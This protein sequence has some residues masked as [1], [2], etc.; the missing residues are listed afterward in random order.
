MKAT[1]DT[2]TAQNHILAKWPGT[3][4]WGAKIKTNFRNA[5]E[6]CKNRKI[7]KNSK[8][9]RKF[10][11]ISENFENFRKSVKT[12]S[13]TGPGQVRDRSGT[14]PGQVQGQVRDRSGTGRK[15]FWNFLKTSEIFRKFSDF[16]ENFW[17][18]LKIFEI[19]WIF[20]FLHFSA[21]FLKFANFGASQWGSGPFGQN[22]VLG[23]WSVAI[24]NV[25]ERTTWPKQPICDICLAR[26]CRVSRRIF[27]QYSG[28]KL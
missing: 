8:N 2:P 4:L 9:F 12:L 18:F 17:N 11:K 5:T 3:P 16:F 14:G 1:Q 27:F 21:A 24:G 26:S 6:K 20:R 28:P 19:F 7:Q 13:G 25:N 10:Q 15:F 23:C 22:M